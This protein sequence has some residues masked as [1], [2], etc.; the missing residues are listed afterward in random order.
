MIPEYDDL[1][2][3]SPQR[4]VFAASWWLD[5]VAPGRWRPHAVERNGQ[6]VAAW[7]TV[8]RETRLGLVHEGAPLTP[9]LG[10]LFRPSESESR[11]Y[12]HELELVE[13]L[14]DELGGFAHLEA[15]CNPAFDYWTPLSW[16]GFT[17]TTQYTWRLDDVSDL[18]GVW[19]G[20]RDNL[21]REVRKARKRGA[22]VAEG[23]L[24]DV[25]ALQQQ[26]AER[27]DRAASAD[28]LSAIDRAAAPQRARSILVARDEDGRPHAA[29]YFVWDDRFTYY[30]VGGSDAE[31]RTSGAVSLLMWTAIEHAAARGTGFDFEGSMLRPVERF[32]RAWGGRPAPYSVV[33]C[34]RSA[35]FRAAVS[36][37]KAARR[38]RRTVS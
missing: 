23:S 4:S 27:Q 8:T 32:F 36:A 9:F 10:P 20:L 2:S 3:S 12:A 11:R 17:Q 38:L 19:S 35:A 21:R 18:D 30:L 1:V 33:R 31:L 24:A 26:T 28:V 15:R 22:T 13:R 5:A 7:P 37:R 16:H 25:Q 29:G 6:L 14:V 34:T